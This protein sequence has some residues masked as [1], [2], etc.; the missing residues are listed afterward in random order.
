MA[1]PI[2]AVAVGLSLHTFA[3]VFGHL[4]FRVIGLVALASALIGS[5]VVPLPFP[6]ST[7]RIPRG[8]A[9]L[10]HVAYSGLFGGILGAGILTALPSVGFYALLA[11]G[12]AATG[13][14][15]VVVAFGA[16]S[17]GRGIPFL[18]AAVSAARRGAYPDEE[19]GGFEKLAERVTLPLELVLLAAIG[20]LLFFASSHPLGLTP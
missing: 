16:F 7:W 13:W 5:G 9:R 20:T 8:W 14:Q 4:P 3:N 2:G 1:L 19:L 15:P 6:E 11:W 12:L 10:G 18:L 17:A